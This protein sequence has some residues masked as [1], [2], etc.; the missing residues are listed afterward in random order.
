MVFSPVNLFGCP[1]FPEFMLVEIRVRDWLRVL[2]GCGKG[3]RQRPKHGK[4][5]PYRRQ[6]RTTWSG[7]SEEVNKWGV[8]AELGCEAFLSFSTHLSWTLLLSCPVP[9]P[10]AIA[11]GSGWSHVPHQ[12]DQKRSP[13]CENMV[14]A[15]RM[16]FLNPELSGI[17]AIYN[18]E[19]PL[20]IE[21]MAPTAYRP[22]EMGWTQRVPVPSFPWWCPDQLWSLQPLLWLREPQQYLLM[23]ATPILF[24]LFLVDCLIPQ[25]KQSCFFF[26]R[27]IGKSIC[28]QMSSCI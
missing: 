18:K 20:A 4:L 22:R 10:W 5:T 25:T 17:H 27:I 7:M 24:D 19:G 3:L 11:T 14:L 6:K 8:K 1:S 9:V 13:Q 21:R 12:V 28:L 23:T 16:S 15:M 26:N 2:T